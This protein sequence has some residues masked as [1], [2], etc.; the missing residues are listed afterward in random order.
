MASVYYIKLV[1]L[2]HILAPTPA[3]RSYI[4]IVIFA[5]TT[6]DKT[7]KITIINVRK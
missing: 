3:G 7:G 1:F 2:R 5:Q 6:G 4:Y